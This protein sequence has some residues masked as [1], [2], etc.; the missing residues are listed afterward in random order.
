MVGEGRPLTDG[1]DRMLQVVCRLC[2]RELD[3][4]FLLRQLYQL[5]AGRASSV[6]ICGWGGDRTWSQQNQAPG[7]DRRV[8]YQI[9]AGQSPFD[10]GVY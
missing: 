1:D 7:P 9:T 6:K 3:I 2:A 4:A 5:K 8:R 10:L